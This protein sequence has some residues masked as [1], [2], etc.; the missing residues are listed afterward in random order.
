[1][2]VYM[3]YDARSEK[4]KYTSCTDQMLFAVIPSKN[5]RCP[6][7]CVVARITF[8]FALQENHFSCSGIS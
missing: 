8:L 6:P 4:C 2:C 1:M 3:S 5:A 7:C